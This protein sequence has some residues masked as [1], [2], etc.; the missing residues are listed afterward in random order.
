MAATSKGRR[1]IAAGS[2]TLALAATPLALA[3]PA[4]SGPARGV[5]YVT[6]GVTKDEADQLR[7]QAAS[8]TLEVQFARRTE[9]G[10]AFAA[11][12]QVRILD[13]SG[14]T[15]MEVPS[16]QPIL[17]ANVPPGR[18]TVEATLEGQ[19]KRASVTVGRGHSAVTLLW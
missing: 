15:V 11:D 1:A 3:Q 17:L 19:T 14:R 9:A 2:L 18:Y 7:Q 8:F 4:T 12:V 13:A 5:E 6:G 10:N 16:A